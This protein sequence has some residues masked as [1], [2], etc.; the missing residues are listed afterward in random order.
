MKKFRCTSAAAYKNTIIPKLKQIMDLLG[1]DKRR[2]RLK[3]ISAS[4]GAVF[5]EE[6]R[7]YVE[8]LRE[9][10]NNPL[11]EGLDEP[12]DAHPLEKRR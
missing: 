3:W 12:V 5:A 8:V 4:E 7:S 11:K 2:L 10:G 6:I 1:V 9:L